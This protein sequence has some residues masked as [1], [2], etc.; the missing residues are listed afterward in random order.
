MSETP[1]R[2]LPQLDDLNRPFW[3]GLEAGELRLQRCAD[4]RHLRYPIAETCPRCLSGDAAWERV[5]GRATV[6]STIVFH[7]LYHRAFADEIPYNVS[8]VEL[9]EGP[10]MISNVVGVAPDAVAVGDRLEVV[11][12]RLPE[13]VTINRFRVVGR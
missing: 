4:C 3:E 8:L 11:F 1:P 9:D 7:Q 12:E 2:P 5:S 6:H 13:G 10:R